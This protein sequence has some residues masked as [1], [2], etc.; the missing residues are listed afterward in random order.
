MSEVF[1]FYFLFQQ[2]FFHILFQKSKAGNHEHLTSVSVY[3]VPRNVVTVNN[4]K[5][6]SQSVYPMKFLCSWGGKENT[7]GTG[8]HRTGKER[9]HILLLG[10]GK[11]IICL[12][13]QL[14]SEVFKTFKSPFDLVVYFFLKD[15]Q[16]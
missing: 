5:K 3:H 10:K 14:D 7:T 15:N 9:S 12:W 16:Q 13:R 1:N 2:L 6:K 8:S 4:T 11:V